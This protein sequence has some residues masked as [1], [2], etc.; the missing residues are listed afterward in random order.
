[1]MIRAARL[2]VGKAENSEAA[3]AAMASE[4]HNQ[5]KIQQ[6]LGLAFKK[7]GVV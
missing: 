5:I 2:T 6:A 4:K 1:M 3:P 7:S